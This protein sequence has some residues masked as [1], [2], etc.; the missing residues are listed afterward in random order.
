MSDI[1]GEA[2]VRLRVLGDKLG[3][4]L[5]SAVVP[6][7]KAAGIKAGKALDD[8]VSQGSKTGTT[9]VKRDFDK[10]GTDL[11]SFGKTAS[12]AVSL[13][14]AAALGYATKAASDLN[15]SVNVTGLTF[16]S[17]RGEVDKFVKSAEG[18]GLSERAARDSTAAIGGLLANMGYTRQEAAA[19]SVEMVKLAADM[20]SAFNKEPAEAADAIA[21]AVRGETEQIR[22]MNVTIDEAAIKQK[23]MELG[24]LSATGE[25][26]KHAK[27]QAVLALI[28]EQTANVAGDYANTVDGAANSQRNLRAEVENQAAALGQSLLPI[29]QK[30]I[31]IASDL[32]GAFAAMPPAAQNV[33]LGL[34]GIAAAAGPIA[35]IVGSGTK[36]LQLFTTVGADGMRS[37]NMGAVGMAAGLAVAMLAV[38]AFT[39]GMVD[40][41]AKAEEFTAAAEGKVDIS[42]YRDLSTALEDNYKA[43]TK[44]GEAFERQTNQWGSVGRAALEFGQ[45]ITPLSN[46]EAELREQTDALAERN[47][48]LQR[49]LKNADSAMDSFGKATGLTRTEVEALAE[50]NSVDLTQS[51]G[52][53]TTAL[54]K[55][56][57]GTELQ[58]TATDKLADATGTLADKTSTAEDKVKAFKTAL[59]NALGITIGVTEASIRH[60]DAIDNLRA[61]VEEHG[62]S[63]DI[64][65]PKSRETA[66]AFNAVIQSA[67]GEVE[68]LVAAGQVAE[69]TAAHKHELTRRLEE[70]KQKFPQL[71]GPIDEYIGKIQAIPDE[72]ATTVTV[73]TKAAEAAVARLTQAINRIPNAFSRGNFDPNAA[74]GE[75]YGGGRAVGGPVEAGKLYAVGERGRTEWFVPST[76]GHV[77]ADKPGSTMQITVPITVQGNATPDT[78]EALR[79]M[80]RTELAGTLTTVLERADAGAGTR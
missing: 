13:P 6:D 79:S 56:H 58:N 2:Y 64:T 47:A 33:A 48:E 75:A 40:A 80:V 59:D 51:Y 52:D 66:S 42:S 35:G 49:Q 30:G 45:L 71:A 21:A 7:A 54:F 60:Q 4:E 18:I 53:I 20:G 77:Y 27:A 15:E 22:A 17:A 50:K 14:I 43:A 38:G 29:L 3:G 34:A 19:T 23:A 26:D 24:L 57:D 62:A 55:A 10:L 31:G 1:L 11:Q 41:K 76:D 46:K 74:I 78:V 25:V 16:G 61:S 68:A 70:L 63:L 28:Q 9:N 65:N 73:D 67:Q 44:S 37:V 12:V 36:A 5:E 69:G 8:G 39:K 32:V 72:K